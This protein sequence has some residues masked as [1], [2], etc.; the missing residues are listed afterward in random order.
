MPP[1]PQNTSDVLA[2]GA[3]DERSR[4]AAQRAKIRDQQLEKGAAAVALATVIVARRAPNT[5]AKILLLASGVDV[6]KPGLLKVTKFAYGWFAPQPFGI[7]PPGV[8][9]LSPGYLHGVIPGLPESLYLHTV[10]PDHPA[11]IK[12]QEKKNLRATVQPAGPTITGAA[13]SEAITLVGDSGILQRIAGLQRARS[14]LNHY[15]AHKLFGGAE[16]GIRGALISSRLLTDSFSPS[17]PL[18]TPSDV[19]PAPVDRTARIEATAEQLGASTSAAALAT[20]TPDVVRVHRGQHIE[21]VA[22]SRV[23]LQRRKSETLKALT[24]GKAPVAKVGR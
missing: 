4:V 1:L 10:G 3:S 15:F 2:N 23:E 17:G 6:R 20:L 18:P 7:I 12:F 5:G 14:D 21:S 13:A 24:A 8:Y 22:P 9:G 16:Q 11:M 19:P